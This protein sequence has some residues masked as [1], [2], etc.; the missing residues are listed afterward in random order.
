MLLMLMFL[1]KEHDLGGGI[2]ED[3]FKVFG[4]LV[5]YPTVSHFFGVKH[6]EANTRAD[7]IVAEV[8]K[9]LPDSN[10]R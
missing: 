4:H 2:T 6:E 1:S 3:G 5:K 8:I 7:S 9:S 10:T